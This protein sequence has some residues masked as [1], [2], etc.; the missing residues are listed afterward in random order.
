ML[1]DLGAPGIAAFV[2]KYQG[3]EGCIAAWKFTGVFSALNEDKD[4]AFEPELKKV[5]M[6]V[7]KFPPASRAI[8][9]LTTPARPM[10]W[11]NSELLAS[12]AKEALKLGDTEKLVNDAA[13]ICGKCVAVNT[14]LMKPGK[15][16]NVPSLNKAAQGTQVYLKARLNLELQDLGPVLSAKLG[17]AASS[18]A[19][20]AVGGE[21]S[22]DENKK[23][24]AEDTGKS[25]LK[26]LR[27]LM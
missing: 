3:I 12:V 5:A 20:T 22:K 15:K 19:E 9:H 18:N 23:V 25:N 27:K 2:D 13:K 1:D 14:L 10:P 8:T 7:N 24:Q 17:H 16:D 4:A 6:A 11:A 26:K 21:S